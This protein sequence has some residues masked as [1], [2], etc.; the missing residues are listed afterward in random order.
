MAAAITK[1]QGDENLTVRQVT[2][3]LCVNRHFQMT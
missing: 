3:S 1:K 2:V